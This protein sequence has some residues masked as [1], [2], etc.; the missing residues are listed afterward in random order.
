MCK[1][2]SADTVLYPMVLFEKNLKAPQGA[3]NPSWE[4]PSWTQVLSA[5][6]KTLVKFGVLL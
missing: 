1:P 5:E 3:R 4:S 2:N 6:M